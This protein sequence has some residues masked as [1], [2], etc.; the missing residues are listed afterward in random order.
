MVF[1]DILVLTV[2][3]Q[4][5]IGFCYSKENSHGR[6]NSDRDNKGI[7]FLCESKET[8]IE[9]KEKKKRLEPEMVI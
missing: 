3:E 4:A 2:Q 5:K 1:G 9:K 8:N 6:R 7:M